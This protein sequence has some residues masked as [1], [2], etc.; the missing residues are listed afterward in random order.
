[1]TADPVGDVEPYYVRVEDF[2]RVKFYRR[3][4][5]DACRPEG[6]MFDGFVHVETGS[7]SGS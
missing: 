4:L 5:F 3:S 6:A 1:V 7:P 2:T